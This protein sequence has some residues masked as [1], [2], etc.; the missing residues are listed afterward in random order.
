[1]ACRHFP[2]CCFGASESPVEVVVADDGYDGFAV[3]C[4][5]RLPTGKELVDKWRYLVG[6]HGLGLALGRRFGHFVGQCFVEFAAQVAVVFFGAVEHV[7]QYALNVGLVGHQGRH[8]VDGVGRFAKWFDVEA[9]CL[10]VGQ[11]WCK[12]DVVV[13]REFQY[14]GE[15]GALRGALL[16]FEL[17][18]YAFVQYALVGALPVY[19]QQPRFDRRKQIF[20]FVAE[21]TPLA[22]ILTS[23]GN[24]S[25]G[26]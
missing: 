22:A 3:G 18:Q 23:D 4:G 11:Q 6:G 2:K 13:G 1:M 20:V 12:D 19:D 26:G 5:V 15:Q 24:V 14:F 9:E 10:Q 21:G 7:V 17:V 16:H 25:M 8:A